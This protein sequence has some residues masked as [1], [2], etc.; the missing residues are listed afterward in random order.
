MFIEL[1][2]SFEDI[3]FINL[4]NIKSFAFNNEL[5]KLVVFYS[6]GDYDYVLDSLDE[7]KQKIKIATTPQSENDLVHNLAKALSYFINLVDE[8]EGVSG[9]YLNG[10]IA[11]W[12]ELDACKFAGLA[13]EEYVEEYGDDFI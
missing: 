8:S 7:I 10:E 1:K 11:L 9:Y 12:R 3:R 4:N 2:Y 5:G 6:D 13:L